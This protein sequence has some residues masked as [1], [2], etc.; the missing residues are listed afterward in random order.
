MNVVIQP[1]IKVKRQNHVSVGGNFLNITHE[2]AAW[3]VCSATWNLGTK[4]AFALG[5]RK[6]TENLVPVGR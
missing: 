4:S 1:E 3:E 6:T 2:R 5:P